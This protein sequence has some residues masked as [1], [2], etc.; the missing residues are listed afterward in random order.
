MRFWALWAGRYPQNLYLQSKTP[1]RQFIHFLPSIV[2]SR[3]CITEKRENYSSASKAPEPLNDMS[4]RYLRGTPSWD[5]PQKITSNYLYHVL[6][7]IFCHLVTCCWKDVFKIRTA[8]LQSL[9]F[10]CSG[11]ESCHGYHQ[12][13]FWQFWCRNWV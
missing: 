2:S 7:L 9:L 4:M 6:C 8:N 11:V 13:Q 3:K 5:I 10:D 1:L 12:W